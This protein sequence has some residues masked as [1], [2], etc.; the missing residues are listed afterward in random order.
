M[1]SQNMALGNGQKS[2]L[3]PNKAWVSWHQVAVLQKA[4][5]DRLKGKLGQE[6]IQAH[7][8]LGERLYYS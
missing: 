1:I 2:T 5:T 6:G 7:E 4:V 3:G 8:I